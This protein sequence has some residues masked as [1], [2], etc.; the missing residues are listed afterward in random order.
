VR[1]GGALGFEFVVL[2]LMT[3]GASLEHGYADENK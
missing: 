2:T 1:H 3:V